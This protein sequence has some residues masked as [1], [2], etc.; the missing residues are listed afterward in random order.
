VTDGAAVAK[1]AGRV[2]CDAAVLRREL[3]HALE[4]PAEPAAGAPPAIV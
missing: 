1:I 4:P 2:G 3:A